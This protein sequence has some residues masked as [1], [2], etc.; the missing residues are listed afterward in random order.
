MRFLSFR[1]AALLGVLAL[2]A[3]STLAACTTPGDEALAKR[4]AAQEELAQRAGVAVESGGG[5]GSAPAAAPSGGAAGGDPVALGKAAASAYGCA[6]CHS[7]T[8][9]AG[10][11]PSWKGLAG[12]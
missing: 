4:N 6:G 3:M 12:S 7:I 2:T 1:R 5:G 10:V 9:Q 11:G 8:G